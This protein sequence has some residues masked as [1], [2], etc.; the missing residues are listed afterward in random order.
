M[1][2]QTTDAG[3]TAYGALIRFCSQCNAECTGRTFWSSS[4]RGRFCF[5]CA[6][7]RLVEILDASKGGNVRGITEDHRF[8]MVGELAEVR[9]AL[10]AAKGA[11][12]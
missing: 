11:G 4:L 1:P 6:E 5:T 7:V 8:F 2:A 3:R 9:A 10:G 12:Q